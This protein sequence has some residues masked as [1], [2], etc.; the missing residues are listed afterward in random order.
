[1]ENVQFFTIFGN[2]DSDEYLKN[3]VDP[4]RHQLAI[5]FKPDPDPKM[6]LFATRSMGKEEEQLFI[7]MK[8]AGLFFILSLVLITLIFNY[9]SFCPP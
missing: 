2:A 9:S 6:F 3:I 5:Y 8:K 1:M 4:L 7:A